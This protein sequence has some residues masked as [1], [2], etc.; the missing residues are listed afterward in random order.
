MIVKNPVPVTPIEIQ[1]RPT[2]R[3]KRGL[4]WIGV[5]IALPLL[6]PFLLLV[7]AYIVLVS[8]GPVLFIQSRVGYGGDR[9]RIYKFRTMYVPDQSRD[10][11]H[12][13]YISDLSR[14]E[15]PSSKPEFADDLIP[16]GDL[17]RK[18]SI[19]EF[20]QLINIALGN[21]SIVGPR[22]DVL[23]LEDYDDT[24]ARRFEV[25]P[26]MTGLWQVSGKNR[27]SFDEM[28]DL[29]LKYIETRS[30]KNDLRIIAKTFRVLLC[31]R[32]E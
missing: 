11:Q 26:G 21:M 32:N 2:P 18:L 13:Q 8:R 9:F 3:W 28:I 27:L 24:Q 7:G 23:R 12:R 25:L 31:E 1:R 20:P 16:G 22:P 10:E 5:V 15:G 29:D 30:L 14:V 19:D 6:A 17:L 4:D